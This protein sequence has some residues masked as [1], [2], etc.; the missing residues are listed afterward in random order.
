MTVDLNYADAP[1][2]SAVA[3]PEGGSRQSLPDGTYQVWVQSAE[4]T[5]EGYQGKRL[6]FPVLKITFR[7]LA[8]TNGAAYMTQQFHPDPQRMGFLKR[9]ANQIW[10]APVP[11]PSQM[12]ARLGDLLDRCFDITVKTTVKGEKSYTNV[13][14]NRYLEGIQPPEVDDLGN[15]LPF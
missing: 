12:E 2:D 5:E 11:S 4:I 10:P 9:L 15:R 6:D 1:F 13:Y 8:D 3:P 14:V 7:E